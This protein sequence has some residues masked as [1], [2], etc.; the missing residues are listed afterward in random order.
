MCSLLF[1]L[2]SVEEKF[3]V[4][5]R[6]QEQKIVAAKKIGMPSS[7]SVLVVKRD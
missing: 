2:L 6:V 1:F 5:I 4:D 3:N 7:L